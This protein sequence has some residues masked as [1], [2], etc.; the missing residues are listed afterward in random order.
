MRVKRV[1]CVCGRIGLYDATVRSVSRLDA[2]SVGD[3][4][5]IFMSPI[6]V[7]SR[8]VSELLLCGS[9]PGRTDCDIL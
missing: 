6:Y 1:T 5:P 2:N 9:N 3:S 7:T 4:S 8:V